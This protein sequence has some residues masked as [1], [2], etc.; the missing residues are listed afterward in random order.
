MS[1]RL[2]FFSVFVLAGCRA[3]APPAATLENVD[4]PGTDGGRGV[5]ARP[6]GRG[7]FPAVLLLHGDYGPNEGVKAQARRL[8]ELGYLVLTPD[9]YRG[10][11]VGDLMEAH[12]MDRGLPQQRVLGDL[13]ASVDLLLDCADVRQGAVGVMGCDMGGGYALD[14]ALADGRLRAVVICYGRLTTDPKALA[15]LR[16]GVL[17]LYAGK[18]E[19]NP[20][21]TLARFRQAMAKAGKR[22]AELHVYP[23]ADHGFLNPPPGTKSR[24][25]DEEAAAN[26]WQR[27]EAFLERE[28]R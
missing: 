5:L 25:A 13:R 24:R 14:A 10:E 21:E 26:A 8:Q 12:I 9:L 23:D 28:L 4:L 17:G 1:R 3:P 7:P 15:P 16:A 11:K 20:K 22:L 18:D 2:L 6:A 27:I 19:G